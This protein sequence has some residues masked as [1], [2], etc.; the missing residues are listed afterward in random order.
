MER[1]GWAQ[2]LEYIRPDD[3]LVVTE[4]SQ[5]TRSLLDLLETTK[6]LEQRQIH[7]FIL[8]RKY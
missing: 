4:L 7:L 2:L 6:I 8:A 1:P 3:I 5:M